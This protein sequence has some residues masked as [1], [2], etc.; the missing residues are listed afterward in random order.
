[1]K[2][3]LITEIVDHLKKNNK[4]SKANHWSFSDQL[5][6]ETIDSVPGRLMR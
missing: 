5:G 6:F 4:C 3:E 1:M 2:S